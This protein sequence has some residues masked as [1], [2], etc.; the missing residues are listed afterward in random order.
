MPTPATNFPQNS[1][2]SQVSEGAAM[3]TREPRNFECPEGGPYDDGRSTR[4][5]RVHD[6]KSPEAAAQRAPRPNSDREKAADQII[7]AFSIRWD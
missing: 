3:N 5:R 4:H 6:E 7:R 2:E 1:L